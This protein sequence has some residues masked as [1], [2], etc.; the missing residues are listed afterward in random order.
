M[1]RVPQKS[2]VARMGNDDLHLGVGPADP[3]QFRD[4]AEI[5]LRFGAQVLQ[6]MFHCHFVN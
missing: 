1:G 4:D 3:P 2:V 6:H 5:D